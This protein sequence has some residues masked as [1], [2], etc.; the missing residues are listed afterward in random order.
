[1]TIVVA[2]G[3]PKDGIVRKT[4]K[5]GDRVL[6]VVTSDVSDEVHVHGYDLKRNVTPA[7]PA[8]I[9]FVAKLPGRFELEL[10]ERGLQIGELT[11]EP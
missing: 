10:E 1:M 5:R 4:V 6:V 3:A 9:A 11:V 7:K 2:N 8:R